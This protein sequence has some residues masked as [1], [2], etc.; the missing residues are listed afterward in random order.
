MRHKMIVILPALLFALAVAFVVYRTP[1]QAEG[2]AG[3]AEELSVATGSQV[4]GEDQ[5]S[6]SGSQYQVP[7]DIVFT[8]PVRTV[9]FSHQ[10]HAVDM[11]ISCNTCHS[12]IFQMKA[13]TAESRDDF[14]MEGLAAGK[15]CGSCHSS[16]S[17]SVFGSDSQCSRCHHGVK[18]LEGEGSGG[19]E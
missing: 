19:E 18:E 6:A 5:Y 8:V 12:K 7:A 9:V 10:K 4:A 1:S 3:T 2:E 16:H 13:G 14:D 17:E 11:G 15:Y